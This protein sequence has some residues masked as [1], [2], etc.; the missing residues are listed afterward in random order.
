MEKNL[1]Q[2]KESLL[3]AF[4]SQLIRLSL[5]TRVSEIYLSLIQVVSFSMNPAH[6]SVS[7]FTCR[8]KSLNSGNQLP[9]FFLMTSFPALIASVFSFEDS[10][11]RGV[12]GQDLS[13]IFLPLLLMVSPF[14]QVLCSPGLYL[15]D[16]V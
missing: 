4:L 15:C 11:H 13:L 2:Y 9:S 14:S 1:F 6:S 12:D 10:R 5:Y 8:F 7:I 16:N 3:C